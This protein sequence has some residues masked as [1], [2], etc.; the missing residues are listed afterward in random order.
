MVA[1]DPNPGKSIRG[2]N[3][4]RFA[5]V[6]PPT[7]EPDSATLAGA[8]ADLAE[9][10]G[11]ELRR[12]RANA[13][14]AMFGEDG[15]DEQ[16]SSTVGRYRLLEH[17]GRGGLGDVWAAHDPH[18]DRTIALKLLRDDTLRRHPRARAQL[19]AEAA[20]MARLTHPNVVRVYDL[21]DAD[22]ELHVAMEY[23]EGQTARAWQM[24]GEHG[25]RE[26]VAIYL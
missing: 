26:I 14:R 5:W 16:P 21:D 22:G 6:R 19:L 1:K 23:V 11:V 2:A 15:E 7:P 10:P 8:L 13:H 25:W 18:L 24:T 20:I 17:I 4:G 9:Q 12:A 3:T